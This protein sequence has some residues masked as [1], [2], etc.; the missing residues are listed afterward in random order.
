MSKATK[1]FAPAQI[2][3]A[4]VWQNAPKRHLMPMLQ[5][6]RHTASAPRCCCRG[7][8]PLAAT[9]LP[10]ATSIPQYQAGWFGSGALA[11][12]PPVCRSSA[13][14]E[15]RRRTHT[16]APPLICGFASERSSCYSCSPVQKNCSLVQKNPILLSK[17]HFAIFTAL[18]FCTRMKMPFSGFCTRTPCR[19]K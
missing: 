18:P 16:D 7:W 5:P 11:P 3:L 2:F 19:L 8:K 4:S 12:V 10:D 15:I 13:F 1:K 17:N 6:P 14:G 9:N